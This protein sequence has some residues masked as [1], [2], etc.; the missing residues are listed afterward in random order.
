MVRIAQVSDA[1]AMAR[2]IVDT[3]LSAHKGQVPEA[4]WRKR[5]EEWTYEASERGWIGTLQAIADD[6]SPREC[7]YL[8]VDTDPGKGSEEIIGLVMG[9]PAEVGPWPNAGEIYALY[10]R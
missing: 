1:P 5:R 6:S 3:W 10:V 2:L 4:Q 7:V 8:A 9:G